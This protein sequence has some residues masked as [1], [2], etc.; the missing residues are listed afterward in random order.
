MD[1]LR[2]ARLRW[3]GRCAA[4]I[5]LYGAIVSG[6]PWWLCLLFITVVLLPVSSDDTGRWGPDLELEPRFP[7]PDDVDRGAPWTE[8]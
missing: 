2:A 1:G 5:G 4:A 7:L 6:R 8:D 3:S